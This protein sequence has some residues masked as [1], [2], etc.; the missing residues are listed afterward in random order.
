M[1]E[2]QEG[3]KVTLSEFPLFGGAW[4]CRVYKSTSSDEL[5]LTCVI[6]TLEG[7]QA[8]K[9]FSIPIYAQGTSR[10]QVRK[11]SSDS[12]MAQSFTYAIATLKTMLR[13]IVGRKSTS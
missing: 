4:K 9:S 3:V 11:T 8:F 1:A 5:Y 12:G 13:S 7:L 6:T 10:G 2:Q